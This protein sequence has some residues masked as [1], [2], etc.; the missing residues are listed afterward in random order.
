MRIPLGGR[1][2]SNSGI[3]DPNLWQVI[4]S[5]C[6]AMFLLSV[7]FAIIGQAQT[8]QAKPKGAEP[9][10]E[11]AI[12]AIL[13]A[14]DKYEVVALP[15]GHGIQDLDDLILT[16]IRTPAFSA[17]VNDIEFECGNALYQPILDRYIVGD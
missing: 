4:R 15:Q 11:A 5:R 2:F 13:A 9:V 8:Q 10:P 3:E 6:V 14:F 12:P 17:K 7:L 16:L 1:I